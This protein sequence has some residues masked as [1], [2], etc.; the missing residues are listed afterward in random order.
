MKCAKCG[1][2]NREG[3][4][5]CNECAAPIEA[6]CPKCG[7]RNKAGAKFCD[8]CGT[9]LVLSAAT[10]PKN[11]NDSTIRV[12]DSPVAENLEGERKTVTALFADIKG[13]MELIE[14]L[15]PE[16][17]RAVVDP[18][19]KL[20]IDA[21][22]RYDGYIVQSTGDGIFAL[23]G[24]PVAHEDHP[25]RAL[26]AA[27]R[28]QDEMRRYS[29]RLRESG[30]PPIEARA[31]I[32]TGEVVVR[33]LKTGG[34]TEYTPIGHS[35]SLAARM[36]T[37]A[38]T[39]SIAVT[40]TT[41]NL[42]AGYFAFKTL[43]PTRVKGV[44][45]PVNVFEVTGLGPLRTR[46]QRAAGRGL[47][48][49]V[50]REAELQQ[51]KH[52]LE[53]ARNG[54]GQMVAAIGEPGVGKSRLFHEFKAVVQGLAGRDASPT[55][56]E[57]YSISHGKASAYLP[58]IELLRDYFRI[59]P[60]DD[61]KQR[62]EKVA[63]KIVILDRSLEDTLPYFYGLLGIAENDKSLAQM[64][65]QIRRRRTYEAIKRVLLRESLNQPLILIFEDLHWIDAD[66]QGLLEVIC[67]SIANARV[68][69]LV[70]YR[71]EY[72]HDWGG[73]SYYTQLRLDPLGP[74]GADEMLTVLLGDSPELAP[75]KQ[76]ISARTEGNPFFIE[77]IVQ[78]L[79]EEGVLTGNGHVKLARPFSQK[80]IPT[81]VQGILAARIDRLPR[82]EKE[83]L[84]TLA[85]IGREF[86]FRLAQY[87]AG[88][89]ESQLDA[90]LAHLQS[91]EFIHEQ[92]A[93]GD[94][95]YIF[96]HAL[97]QEVAYNSLLIERRK[98]LHERIAGAI[99]SLFDERLDDHL[100][101]LAHHYRRSNNTVKAVEYL[102]RA[103]EQAARRAFYEEAIERLNSALELWEK[104]EPGKARDEDEIAIR[105]VLMGS[106]IAIRSVTDRELLLNAER[107]RELC[108]AAG[109]TRHLAMVLTHLFFFHRSASLDEATTFARRAMELAEKRRAEFEI[110]WGNFISGVLAADKGEY[111]AARRH[112]ER[113]AAIGQQTEDSIIGNPTAALG[114]PNSIGYLV[115]VCW[116]LGYPDEA[117]RHA[118]RLAELLLK[119]LPANAYAVGM[120]HLLIMRCDFLRDYRGARVQAQDALD[121]S[122]QRGYRFGMVYGAIELG[123]IMVA[124]EEVDAG[125]GKMAEEMFALERDGNQ[126]FANWLAAGAYLK[127]RHVTQGSAIV[128]QAIGEVAA[129]CSRLFEADV[130]RIKGELALIAGE[131]VEAEAAFN[132]AIAI[133]RRQQAKSFELRASISL[134]RLLAQQGRRN[135]ACTTLA[136]IYNWFTEGFDT[137]D[138]KD[139]RALLDE[140]SA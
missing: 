123:S 58:V 22:H 85:A 96:K 136:K 47:T 107:V 5:F 79:F 66:T 80:S 60:E 101:D 95:E 109:E 42:C 20:M 92:P 115:A 33:T 133:A 64:D 38:P 65:P 53:L 102:R 127:A 3:A 28:M 8:E 27:L 88:C 100:K 82:E 74:G 9:S 120:H 91:A 125:I 112:F 124:E 122:T 2:D 70:N 46:F 54:H 10:A 83:L 14:G 116:I 119:P 130:H 18:A 12:I 59:L 7:S 24:A 49:F 81:S 117:R 21:V 131:A 57:A 108:E 40:E 4:K 110:F 37:L 55:V 111:P 1:A 45:E 72:R 99:E 31:G 56:L 68:L 43:G 17:A 19:L 134:A 63:G 77:E 36:Q 93:P 103:G 114:F 44:T 30:N 135:E 16:E 23:F 26:Y 35:T 29:T 34:H 69:L 84:Q 48:R 138:L 94:V 105:T 128:E 129:G 13:S 121:R 71:P 73:R 39:G 76:V 86:P 52:A 15:D 139:A 6:S 89:P 78:G 25:Q 67:D 61:A 97:T 113:A 62:R 140:L 106:F 50:R 104:L 132:S 41:E 51:M 126:H 32:N 87:V 118:K 137:A 11:P 75:L 98:L 90:A